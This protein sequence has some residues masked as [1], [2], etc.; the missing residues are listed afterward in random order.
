MV[1]TG[2]AACLMMSGVL[3]AATPRMNKQIDVTESGGVT[4]IRVTLDERATYETGNCYLDLMDVASPWAPGT[5]RP[6]I[7][8]SR[9]KEIVVGSFPDRTRIAVHLQSQAPCSISEAPGGFVIEV[10][11]NAPPRPFTARR[12]PLPLP[13]GAVVRK[14][15][16][17]DTDDKRSEP[18][19]VANPA[20]L[21]KPAPHIDEN[22]IALAPTFELSIVEDT[23]QDLPWVL[24]MYRG[25]VGFGEA[26]SPTLELMFHV[27][28]K[29]WVP[30]PLPD[31]KASLN[32]Y[33]ALQFTDNRSSLI[34]GLRQK[35]HIPATS[36]AY[37]LFPE[38]F[39]EVIN[40][41]VR[42][43]AAEKGSR[44][45]IMGATIQFSMEDVHGIKVQSVK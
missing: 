12:T 17:A 24:Q 35:N 36:A 5:G 38:T 16:P 43:V 27:S 21:P 39:R 10:G 42:H 1:N 23:A 13:P 40:E 30:I 29:E 31:G 11:G 8:D 19:A 7:T 28:D 34:E 22:S 32:D 37:A 15:A 33:F 26:K 4:R 18:P 6:P 44:G 14:K 9:V 2:L 25:F 45:P 20:P 41:Q 3:V